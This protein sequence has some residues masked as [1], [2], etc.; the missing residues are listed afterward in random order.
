MKVVVIGGGKVGYYLAKT[1]MEHGHSP[2]MVE[3]D[4]NVC[5]Y[6]ANDLDVPV[7]CGDGT[8]IHTLEHAIDGD[9]DALVGV[10]GKD[11]NNLICCQLAKK[12]FHIEKTVAKVNNPKNAGIMRQLGIDIAVSSTD[13]IARLIEREVDTSVIKQLISLNQGE[14]SINEVSI[15]QNYKLNGKRLM[16]IR[17]PEQSIVISITR[18]GEVLI[19]RGN[20]PILSGDRILIMAKNTALHEISAVLKL[21]K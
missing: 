6:L 4:K 16:E 10:T 14:S 3:I 9:V 1:L 15:P 7:V 13:N 21:D 8:A 2:I 12:M 5:R 11:E 20:T 19:P 18:G 17:M